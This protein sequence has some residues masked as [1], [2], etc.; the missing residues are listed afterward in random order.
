MFIKRIIFFYWMNFILIEFYWKF[1]KFSDFIILSVDKSLFALKLLIQIFKYNFNVIENKSIILFM[2]VLQYDLIYFS[3]KS[4][5]HSQIFLIS[6]SLFRLTTY[7]LQCLFSMLFKK[8]KFSSVWA[9]CEMY[10]AEN[11]TISTK[12]FRISIVYLDL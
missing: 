3:L 4:N 2:V 6:L 9:H 11:K 8:W 5:N 12:L 10:G 1:V 7:L